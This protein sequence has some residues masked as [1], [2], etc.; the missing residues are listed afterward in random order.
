MAAS[1]LNLDLSG[2]DPSNAFTAEVQVINTAVD[3]SVWPANHPFYI[4]D[5]FFQVEGRVGA[6]AW[7][8]MS[9]STDFSFSP[10]FVE[11]TLATG[12]EI[13][14]YL[15]VNNSSITSVRINY[16]ALGKYVDE[17]VASEVLA[18]TNA[19][20]LDRS[21]VISW[22]R[23]KGLSPNYAPTLDPNVIG[24]S[25][26]ELMYL[27][28]ERIRAA[29]LNPNSSTII[30]PKDITEVY[31]ALS[32][33]ASIADIE[34]K[35]SSITV[36]ATPANAGEL[37]E[38]YRFSGNAT[39]LT[40][41]VHCTATGGTSIGVIDFIAKRQSNAGAWDVMVSP[42]FPVEQAFDL[43]VSISGSD[44]VLLGQCAVA[45]TYQFKLA[46]VFEGVV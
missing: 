11:Y 25:A 16:R 6:G 46:S 38:I 23:V 35:I 21:S 40:G 26:E 39:A 18:L 13:V 5:G 9:E 36:P 17:T 37:K 15:V 44:N 28:L 30:Q 45:S 27:G 4:N 29:I 14:S 1:N 31:L 41:V 19:G 12:K 24:R 20:K 10:S 43:A 22:Q 42:S 34:N 32:S 33:K 8:P 7:F 3:R 2:T